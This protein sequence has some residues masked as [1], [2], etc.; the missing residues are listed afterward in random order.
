MDVNLY[1]SITTTNA[2][3]SQIQLKQLSKLNLEECCLFI[4]GL[5]Y[6]DERIKFLNFVKKQLPKIH[7]PFC[8]IRIDSTVQELEFLINN[9][10]TEYFNIHGNHASEFKNLEIYKYR[11]MILAE[12]SKTLNEE[13]MYEGDFAGICLDLS[14]KTEDILNKRD[15]AEDLQK[16]IDNYP[17][18]ANHIS[19]VRKNGDHYHA[20]HILNY[21]SDMDYLKEIDLK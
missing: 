21:K 7:I 9:F 20:E 3:I 5:N 2:E 17:I 18:I 1:P 16:T 12:N 19:S 10:G 8:H 15:W 6:P 13:Q 11:N 14:H 4:T